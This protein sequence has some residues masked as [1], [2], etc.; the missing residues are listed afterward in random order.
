MIGGHIIFRVA[1]HHHNSPPLLESIKHEIQIGRSKLNPD[2][3][4]LDKIWVHK[5]LIN[6]KIFIISLTDFFLNFEKL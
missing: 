4:S 3:N 2:C 5:Y 1:L 6:N